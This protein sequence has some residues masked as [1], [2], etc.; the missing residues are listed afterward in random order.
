MIVFTGEFGT[1]P[2]G[3][4]NNACC[5][6]V[7][8]A[9]R[10][11]KRTG[12]DSHLV[13]AEIIR[14]RNIL[15]WA[16]FLLLPVGERHPIASNV[17]AGGANRDDDHRHLASIDELAP[18]FGRD[19]HGFSLGDAELLSFNSERKRPAQDDVHLFLLAVTVNP[20][21]LPRL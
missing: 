21:A 14:Q 8:Q 10:P 5:C 18:D 3:R 20:P 4:Q 9:A 1:E 11:G 15:G 13:F 16:A 7:S 17:L 19:P 12:R 2:G 6:T